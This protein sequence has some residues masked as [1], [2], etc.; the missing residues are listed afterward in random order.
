MSGELDFVLV[1]LKSWVQVHVGFLVFIHC[2][3]QW[4]FIYLRIISPNGADCS[5]IGV[6]QIHKP[7]CGLVTLLLECPSDLPYWPPAFVFPSGTSSMPLL[8]FQLGA[9]LPDLSADAS[10]NELS[11]SGRMLG[12]NCQVVVTWAR[13]CQGWVC[14]PASQDD[15]VIQLWCITR[16]LITLPF[17]FCSFL[18]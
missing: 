4:L 16:C 18:Q 8:P 2:R 6:K 10:P 9:A 3:K 15:S 13:G 14:I 1:L 17:L 7:L 11:V 5:S 12:V